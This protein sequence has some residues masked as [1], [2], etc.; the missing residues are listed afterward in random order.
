[1]LAHV[2]KLLVQRSFRSVVLLQDLHRKPARKERGEGR[3]HEGRGS[4]VN[5]SEG[6]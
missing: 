6:S 3:E 1:M 2:T 5:E 4:V